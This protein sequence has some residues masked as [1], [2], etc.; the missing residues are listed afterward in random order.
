M[1]DQT[2]WDATIDL[3]VVGSGNGAMTGAI[4]AHDMGI[5]DIHVIE[6]SEFFGGTSGLSGGGIWIPCNR[7]A[8]AEGAVDSIEDAKHYLDQVVP[9][10]Q[11][12]EE[13]IDTYLQNAPKMV[14]FMHENTQLQY[15]SL[16]KYPDYYTN[17]EG[18]REGHRSLE[19]VPINRDLLGDWVHKLVVGGPMFINNRIA[20]TQVEGQILVGKLK[21]YVWIF[22]KRVLSYLWDRKWRKENKF[23][24]RAT[25]GA[26]GIIRLWLSL[27]DRNI[28]L[29]LNTKLT[30]LIREGDHVTGVEI[31]IFKDK[32]IGGQSFKAGD[33]IKIGCNKGVIL[34]AGGFE[35]NQEMREQYLP[36]PTNTEWSAGCFSNT[37]DAI[38]AGQEIGAATRLMQNAWWCTTLVVP[39]LKYPFLSIVT[40]SL[41]GCITVNQYGKRFSN[42]SQNYMAFQ[43]EAFAKH[44]EETPSFPMYMIFD[45]NFKANYAVF[46][47]MGPKHFLPGRLFKE[48]FIAIEDTLDNL[49]KAMDIDPQGLANTVSSFNENAAKGEDPEFDRGK[50][51]YDRYYGDPGVT[52]NPCLAPIVKPPFYAMRMEPG[53]FGT[54]GGLSTNKNGQVLSTEG[55]PIEG[56]YACGNCSAA[57]LPTYPGPGSTLGPAMTFAYL[58][59]KHL[60]KR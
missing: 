4:C 46:P 52:P 29:H 35:Q 19:P 18:S 8:A 49:A 3:L 28:P 20:I 2:P 16:A 32:T 41:P 59:A 56:L 45:H 40:K 60:T 43:Q 21:G 10:D 53:D 54:Q 42:E 30:K 13:M 44:S 47:I 33:T 24:R 15:A 26:A 38:R 39:T 27:K 36:Q 12:P 58:A 37:G 5:R 25:A 34:A 9:A 6:K 17:L 48:K 57:I 51:A 50:S 55:T 1:S 11:V 23:S 31:K 7:Y 22:L 14:D